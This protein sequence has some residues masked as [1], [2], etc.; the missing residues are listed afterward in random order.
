M[1]ATQR[2]RRRGIFPSGGPVWIPG[3]TRQ[4]LPIPVGVLLRLSVADR[5]ANFN[6]KNRPERRVGDAERPAVRYDAERVNEGV[7]GGLSMVAMLPRFWC[8][9][10][11]GLGRI[12]EPVTLSRVKK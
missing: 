7:K 1:C 11:L 8:S 12:A 10:E 6:A 9:G 2:A 5:V 3:S 4:A